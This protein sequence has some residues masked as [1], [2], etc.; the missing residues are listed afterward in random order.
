MVVIV[1]YKKIRGKLDYYHIIIT[2]WI[3]RII[4]RIRLK[5]K[6]FSIIS[7]NCVGGIIMEDLR[8]PFNSPT[9]GLSI[10]SSD[11]IRMCE[12][13]KEYMNMEIVEIEDN[14]V[15]YPV[16]LLGDVRLEFVH[17]KTFQEAVEKW[18]RRKKRIYYD[19][20]YICMTEREDCDEEL[21]ERFENLP[22]RNKVWFTH[23]YRKNDDCI[24]IPGYEENGLG[25]LL[26]FTGWS[27]KRIYE[28]NFDHISWLNRK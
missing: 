3:Y 8:L 10:P 23:L 18:E 21:L 4:N 11:F 7:K 24:Y 9:A 14:S 5:N 27:K 1:M 28:T 22:Y 13:L 26:A 6:D 12:N 16:G 19:N 25:N 15:E 17:Y 2:R 20:L